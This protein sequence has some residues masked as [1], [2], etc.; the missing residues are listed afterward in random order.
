V[1]DA[2]DVQLVYALQL[3]GRASFS[4]IGEVLGVSDQ[5]I[6]RR[7]HRLRSAGQL[8]VRGLVEPDLIGLT[9]WL[10]RVQCTPNAAA[11]VAEALARRPDTAWISLTSGG[12]EVA[13]VARTRSGDE[14]SHLLLDTLPRSRG[15]TG[16]TAQ[17]VLHTYFGGVLSLINKSGTLTQDQV[18]ALQP[19]AAQGGVA[20]GGTG[21]AAPG[22]IAAEDTALLAALELDGRTTHRDLAA[23]TGW[24]QTTVRRRIAD[25]QA[26]GMLYFDVDFH[27]SLLDLSARGMVWLTVSPD[28]L[29][30]AGEAMARHPETAYVA[31]TTGKANLYASVLSPSTEALYTYLTA[32]IAQ[33]P[34]LHEVETVMVMRTVKRSGLLTRP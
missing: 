23:A 9:S 22:R 6:A 12:T 15:V 14:D 17:C 7:Y 13:C 21:P 25:L 30:A 3:D 29:D 4:L 1:P 33:L 34:G 2:L 28:R 11:A 24:S 10:I 8:R 16:I 32:D 31:A 26:S 20:P 5:T 18:A 19:A 27:H